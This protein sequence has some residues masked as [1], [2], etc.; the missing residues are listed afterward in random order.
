M[1]GTTMIP[2]TDDLKAA[3]TAAQYAGTNSPPSSIWRIGTVYIDPATGKKYIFLYNAG[4]ASILASE[5]AYAAGTDMHLY[6]C[7][8]GSGGSNVEKFAGARIAGATAL[9]TLQYGWFQIGG[10]C[11]LK[12]DAAGT[13]AN[14]CVV[15]SNATAGAIEDAETI[16]TGVAAMAQ[17]GIAETTVTSDVVVVSITKNCWGV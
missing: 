3:Y 17:F 10:S 4:A 12:A 16:N 5:I 6:Q 2:N 8:Q 14:K 1:F 9:A 7:Q 15:P 13:A 11:T